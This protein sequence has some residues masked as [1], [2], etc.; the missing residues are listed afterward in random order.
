MEVA[1]GRAAGA[2]HGASSAGWPL[3]IS[4]A[5]AMRRPRCIPA[6]RRQRGRRRTGEACSF[7]AARTRGVFRAPGE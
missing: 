1:R 2:R 3:G 5:V 6:Q 4:A 7:A